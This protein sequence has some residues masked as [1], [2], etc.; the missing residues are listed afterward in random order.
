MTGP[1]PHHHPVKWGDWAKQGNP[2]VGV[3]YCKNCNHDTHFIW[4]YTS[5]SVQSSF[6]KK[7]IICNCV[8]SKCKIYHHTPHKT[9]K[10]KQI[11]ISN[12][13][14]SYQTILGSFVK[15]AQCFS[16]STRQPLSFPFH[17]VISLSYVIK[18]STFTAFCHEYHNTLSAYHS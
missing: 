14:A 5:L 16:F 13:L 9:G 17:Y 2:Q 10:H 4:K 15:Y 3:V 1:Q 7:S 11:G 8:N 18:H 6:T 12:K